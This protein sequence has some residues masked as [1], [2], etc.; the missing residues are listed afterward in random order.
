M[1]TFGTE[2]LGRPVDRYVET[3][4]PP[5]GIWHARYYRDPAI[6]FET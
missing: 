1:T 6:K 4:E 2:I 3:D 5:E